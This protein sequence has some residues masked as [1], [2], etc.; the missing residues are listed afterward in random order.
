MFHTGTVCSVLKYLYL[1]SLSMFHTDTVCSVLEYLYLHSLSVFLKVSLS[2]QFNASHMYI[3]I[4]TCVPECVC[5][6][7]CL[8]MCP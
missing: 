2:A 7:Q 6:H 4:C 8:Q 3:Y 5:V 1:H